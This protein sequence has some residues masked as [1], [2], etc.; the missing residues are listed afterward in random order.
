MDGDVMKMR[1]VEGGLSIAA[2]ATVDL[3]PGG[4]HVMLMGLKAP[5]EEG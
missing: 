2:G 3:K 4:Y 5:L 1:E